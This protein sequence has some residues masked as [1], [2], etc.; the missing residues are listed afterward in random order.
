MSLF[1]NAQVLAE[2]LQAESAPELDGGPQASPEP[3]R[4][5]LARM[6][7]VAGVKQLAEHV[8]IST[9]ATRDRL[10]RSTQVRKL[11][12]GYY[13]LV[14]MPV[15]PV[16]RWTEAYL[17]LAGEIS[18]EEVVEAILTRFPRGHRRSVEAWLRQEPEHIGVHGTR[19]FLRD[20]PRIVL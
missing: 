18:F 15:P 7:G 11:G 16:G 5:I 14:D 20:I 9:R 2:S 19:V 17:R 8:G 4:V 10:R 6:G 1:P 3:I 12:A 13:A